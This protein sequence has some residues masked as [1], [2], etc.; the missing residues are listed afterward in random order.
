MKIRTRILIG[1]LTVAILGFAYLINWVLR[2]LRPHYLKSMEE[3]L[4][5]T[6]T[7]LSSMV[8]IQAHGDTLDVDQLER[9]M[10]N[11]SQQEISAEIYDLL[12]TRMNI[13]VYIT[14]T[15]GIVIYDSDNGKAEG[16]DFSQWNDV[17][18][19]LQGNYGARATPQTLGDERT[20]VLY[21]AS[22][23]FIQNRLAGVLTVSKPIGSV[24]FFVQKGRR[25]IL[26]A[27]LLVVCGVA[28]IGYLLSIWVTTPIAR[29]T[30]YARAVKDGSNARRPRSKGE[31]ILGKSEIDTMGEAFEEMRDTLEGKKY[32]EQYVQTLTHEIKSP[33]SAI[34]GAAEL[35]DEKMDPERRKKFLENIRSE[36]I[37]IQNIVD[38]MLQL[39]ALENRKELRDIEFVDIGALAKE[40]VNDSRPLIEKKQLSLQMEL[41]EKLVVRGERFLLRQALANLV[42]NAVEFSPFKGAIGITANKHDTTAQIIITDSGPG[43]PDYARTKI[44]DRFYSL[45]RLDTNKKSTGLGLSF[46]GEVAELHGGAISVDNNNAGSGAVAVFGVPLA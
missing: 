10:H 14:D 34:Q 35:M 6:G 22:P 42:Q 45:K 19:T 1:F 36:T 2:D 5:D 40:V 41:S 11:A 33:V 44:F 31:I 18:L 17:R 37:R 46:V 32:V 43:I 21:V 4:V 26:I 25:D 29:L 39:A 13:R 12:K 24:S 3:S 38:R 9:V 20:T 28:V 15:A 23:L 8:S 7:L 27:G 16:T 30:S